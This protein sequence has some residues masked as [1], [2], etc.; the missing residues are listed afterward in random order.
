MDRN[1]RKSSNNFAHL[2]ITEQN[3]RTSLSFALAF[4]DQS[5]LKELY[6]YKNITKL[7]KN[8]LTKRNIPLPISPYLSYLSSKKVLFLDED[9]TADSLM[10]SNSLTKCNSFVSTTSY[11]ASTNSDNDSDSSP[12]GLRKSICEQLTN[13]QNK[14]LDRS[15][16]NLSIDWINDKEKSINELSD[17][18]DENSDYQMNYKMKKKFKNPDKLDHLILDPNLI[19]FY[20]SHQIK[21]S[22]MYTF[23]CSENLRREEYHSHYRNY[24]GDIMSSLSFMEASCPVR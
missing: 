22:Q 20:S 18:E 4:K 3:L 6:K 24:H 14:N 17:T 19:E 23:I 1:T 8:N 16:Q 7:M 9:P 10:K 13:Q 2:K 12:K 5:L 11:T 21:P 15:N